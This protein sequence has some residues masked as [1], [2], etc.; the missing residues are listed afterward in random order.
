MQAAVAERHARGQHLDRPRKEGLGP[1]DFA[2]LSQAPAHIA[3]VVGKAVNQQ[4][5]PNGGN[6]VAASIRS[7]QAAHIGYQLTCLRPNIEEGRVSEFFK[8]LFGN[9]AFID[10]HHQRMIDGRGFLGMRKIAVDKDAAPDGQLI[11]P[12]CHIDTQAA[13]DRQNDLNE[14][15]SLLRSFLSV[16]SDVG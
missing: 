4:R 10:I 9:H 13:G 1:H 12:S 2:Q 11:L 16:G 6:I 5:R 7:N 8:R 15:V 3:L 14:C